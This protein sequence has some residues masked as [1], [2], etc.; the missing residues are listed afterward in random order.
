MK[1][2]I[3]AILKKHGFHGDGTG[4]LESELEELMADLDGEAD[5]Y[6]RMMRTQSQELEALREEI[7]E[8]LEIERPGFI[9]LQD[10]YVTK[11]WRIPVIEN[12]L[13]SL[14]P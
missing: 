5:E 7:A 14:K 13:K 12:I 2:K 8:T 3:K 11:A 4:T 1:D 9:K 6:C 10:D